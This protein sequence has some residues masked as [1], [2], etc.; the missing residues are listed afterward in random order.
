MSDPAKPLK[1]LPKKNDF[2]VG[3]DSDGC[4]FDSMGI[5]QREC[6]C[7]WYIAYFDL[8]PVA[9]IARECKDF[10]DLFS[11]TRGLNR[12]KT[13]ARILTELLPS[14]PKVQERG[15]KVPPFK[16]YCDWVN[17]PASK[18]SDAG[19]EEA[20]ANTSSQEQKAE[21]QRALEW[22]KK[23]NETVRA[24]VKNVPPFQYVRESLEKLQG[25]ADV[26]VC[27]QTPCEALEREWAEHSIDGY[28]SVI[29]GQEMGTKSE[30]LKIAIDSKYDKD[31][32]LMIGDAPGD[33]KAAR[34]NGILFF[35]INPHNGELSW[36]RFYEEAFD[37]FTAGEYAGEYEDSLI[38]EFHDQLPENPSWV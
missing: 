31:K 29:A 37:K 20:I 32:C 2:F 19:L 18:L 3:I 21:L 35:P 14:H 8:Q 6:F 13:I 10:A 25:K 23:V 27:S 24:I 4:V 30:H 15:F 28:V 7:P 1:D 12:H 38:K 22:S 36:K 11:K 33:E 26:I 16:F 34:D 17:N 9:E 5:K